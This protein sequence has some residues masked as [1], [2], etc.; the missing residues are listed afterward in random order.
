MKIS[1][2]QKYPTFTVPSCTSAL[3]NDTTLNNMY[4]DHPIKQGYYRRTKA[5]SAY[6]KYIAIPALLESKRIATKTSS[7][8]CLRQTTTKYHFN[9]GLDGAIFPGDHDMKNGTG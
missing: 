2:K 1:P 9:I 4:H 6:I 3:A 7:S 5:K 8:I